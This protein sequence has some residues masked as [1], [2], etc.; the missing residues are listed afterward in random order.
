MLPYEYILMFWIGLCPPM[1]FY[2]MNP[3]VEAIEDA[4]K[5]KYNPDCWNAAQAFS[6]DDVWRDR[7]AKVYFLFISLTFTGLLF[8]Y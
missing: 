8:I 7:V 4:K 3:R 5:G 2:I 1:F 6:N